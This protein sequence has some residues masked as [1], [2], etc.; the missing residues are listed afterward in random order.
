MDGDTS[1]GVVTQP[2]EVPELAHYS[3]LEELEPVTAPAGTTKQEDHTPSGRRVESD[4]EVP[5]SLQGSFSGREVGMHALRAVSRDVVQHPETACKVVP[6][7]HI[8]P[9]YDERRNPAAPF[10]TQG[11]VFQSPDPNNP[12]KRA[13]GHENDYRGDAMSITEPGRNTTQQ[14]LGMSRP[15]RAISIDCKV[16]CNQAITYSFRNRKRLHSSA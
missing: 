14:S 1:S 12:G 5:P 7:N 15:R 13:P 2:G 6:G 3:P 16:V 4:S 9:P 11:R 8:M 10:P